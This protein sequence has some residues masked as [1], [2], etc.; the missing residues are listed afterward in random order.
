MGGHLASYS[1]Y[2]QALGVRVVSWAPSGQFIAVGSYD[3]KVRLLN[4]LTWHPIAEFAHAAKIESDVFPDVVLYIEA[5]A[6][7]TESIR[8]D[9]EVV[10]KRPFNVPCS[11]LDWDKANPKMGI[12]AAKFSQDGR[13]LATLNENM[14]CTMWIWSIR[15]VNLAA[16]IQCKSAVTGFEWNPVNSRLSVCTGRE[17][18]YVWSTESCRRFSSP[19]LAE[20]SATKARWSKNG[21]ML[22]ASGKDSVCIC[23]IAP[24]D[25]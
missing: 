24:D 22:A 13:H 18:I 16:I 2:Q 21:E 9:L 1:A 15:S 25:D 19:E 10:T 5:E 14:P 12:C 8:E 7:E 3:Q 6:S 20:V 23:W 11:K 4:N 17:V